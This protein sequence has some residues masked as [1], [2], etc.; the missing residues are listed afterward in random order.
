MIRFFRIFLCLSVIM[1]NLCMSAM[2]K[3]AIDITND[4]ALE[5]VN[6]DLVKITDNNILTHSNSENITITGK[7]HIP[8]EGIY[9]KYNKIPECGYLNNNTAIAQ[10]GFLH[11]FIELSG[12]KEFTLTYP[13]ADICDI[14]IF[15]EGVLP[16]NVQKWETGDLNT[17]ILLCAT[18]SDDD[19]LFFAGLLPYYAGYKNANVRVAYFAN[20]YDTYN[21]THELLDGLWHCGIKNYPDISDFPD[22]YSESVE[23]AEN[24]LKSKGFEYRDI[25]RFQRNLIEEY[26]PLVVVLHDFDGEYGHGAHMLNTKSF[27]ETFDIV[28]DENGYVPQKIY[29]H[30]YPENKIELDIDVSLDVFNGKSAFNISQEAFG[31]HKSQH[32]TWFYDWIYGKDGKTSN[33]TQIRTYNPRQYGLYYSSVGEDINKNDILENVLIYAEIKK[34]EMKKQLLENSAF[35]K[36]SRM[37]E[38]ENN[39]LNEDVSDQN[40]SYSVFIIM[41]IIAIMLVVFLGFAYIIKRKR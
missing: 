40:G 30:L 27:I 39:L 34:T 14:Q 19:Q 31:F 25:I 24:F 21:R 23:G 8:L 6:I 12:Q 17:D 41:F 32:W 37:F 20:H 18:H 1:I 16:C 33:S 10:N 13:F 5:C 36:L 29:V 22:G 3:E 2:A 28:K 38:T 9:I 15:S 4:L 7:S 26:K 35:F 11:E